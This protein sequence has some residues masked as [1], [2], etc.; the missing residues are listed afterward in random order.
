MCLGFEIVRFP[1]SLASFFENQ[2]SPNLFTVESGLGDLIRFEVS[3]I[4]SFFA[5]TKKAAMRFRKVLVNHTDEGQRDY[6][7]NVISQHNTYRY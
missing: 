3:F 5:G 6:L 2:F 4:S 7:S 1:G